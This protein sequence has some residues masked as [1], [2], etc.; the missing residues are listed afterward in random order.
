M[1]DEERATGRRI[2]S[3]GP[4]ELAELRL[5][6][7]LGHPRRGHRN[8]KDATREERRRP[9]RPAVAEAMTEALVAVSAAIAVTVF[10][11]RRHKLVDPAGI[12]R[13]GQ[14]EVLPQRRRPEV[15]HPSPVDANQIEGRIDLPRFG[16]RLEDIDAVKRRHASRSTGEE[17]VLCGL[18]RVAHS[19]EGQQRRSRLRS[20]HIRHH[21]PPP[22]RRLPAQRR[23]GVITELIHEPGAGVERHHEQPLESGRHSFLVRRARP[24]QKPQPVDPLPAI[25]PDERREP[26][27]KLREIRP[28]GLEI[29]SV[30]PMHPQLLVDQH[31]PHRIARDP[32]H[33]LGHRRGITRQIERFWHDVVMAKDSFDRAKL[34]MHVADPHEAIALDAVPEVVLHAEVNGVGPHFPHPVE[35]RIARAKGADPGQ[36]AD[37]E[38]RPHLREHHRLPGVDRVDPHKPKSARADRLR[39]Q[40][41]KR[42]DGIADRMIVLGVPVAEVGHRLACR[43]AEAN[44]NADGVLRG[45]ERRVE[46]DMPLELTAKV[47]EHASGPVVARRQRA[48]RDGRGEQGLRSLPREQ[49]LGAPHPLRTL[50]DDP[51][52]HDIKLADRAAAAPCE[53]GL[54]HGESLPTKSP[55]HDADGHH[56]RAPR[57]VAPAHASSFSSEYKTRQAPRQPRPFKRKP[58]PIDPPSV[59]LHPPWRR[60]EPKDRGDEHDPLDD[61]EGH[62]AKEKRH[63]RED[64]AGKGRQPDKLG[65]RVVRRLIRG[66]HRFELR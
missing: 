65:R 13:P 54:L 60:H 40:P 47:E 30:A 45:G 51:R 6:A 53:R 63:R 37:T 18:L 31:P 43:F 49:R 1:T 11:S 28:L 4:L 5:D 48:G 29:G 25:R 58:A 62:R 56:H 39:P 15:E 10:F 64:R 2:G 16:E 55:S 36:I 38:L 9:A 20:I 23:H 57:R 8:P 61:V 34:R 41:G 17:G 19:G 59:H 44:A 7:E 24:V 66:C 14:L 21:L 12:F 42:D 32:V 50:P 33:P 35:P 52:R 3:L 46:L 26:L 27:E 22:I